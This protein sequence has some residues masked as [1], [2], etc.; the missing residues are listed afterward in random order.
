MPREQFAPGDTVYVRW[1]GLK[2]FEILER[3]QHK[4]FFPHWSCQQLNS[5]KKEIWI[6]PQ[7]HLSRHNIMFLTGEHNRKQLALF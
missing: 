1:H 7:I 5:R 6:F 4:S 3:V 2:Q